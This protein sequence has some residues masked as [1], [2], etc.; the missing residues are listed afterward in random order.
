MER[1][2]ERVIRSVGANGVYRGFRYAITA[3][4]LVVLDP[5]I[6]H[7]ATTQLYPA[8]AWLYGTSWQCVERDIRTMIDVCWNRD[9]RAF[10]RLTG[11]E[12]R[13]KP[14]VR[15]FVDMV[16]ARVRQKSAPS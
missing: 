11:V 16:A 14:T 12:L 5:G 15:E 2:I 9:S 8:V 10:A 3:V 1:E 6:L 4:L 13:Y 7:T